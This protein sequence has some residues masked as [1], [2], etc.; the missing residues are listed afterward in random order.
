MLLPMVQFAQVTSSCGTTRRPNPRAQR[1]GRPATSVAVRGTSSPHGPRSMRELRQL[2]FHKRSPCSG[3]APRT[4]TSD[5]GVGVDVRRSWTAPIYDKASRPGRGKASAQ[6]RR[7]S[8]SALRWRPRG[9]RAPR[10]LQR[11][12]KARRDSGIRSAPTGPPPLVV[13]AG[14]RRDRT[15]SV[16]ASHARITEGVASTPTRPPPRAPG[17]CTALQ[18]GMACRAETRCQ[19]PQYSNRS[20]EPK[21]SRTCCYKGI[22]RDCRSPVRR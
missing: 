2:G 1:K 17:R 15:I 19:R 7:T 12:V 20:E 6:H 16:E 22:R 9:R 13:A 14:R 21:L 18:E 11:G 4:P 5:Q 3:L 8:T 10:G